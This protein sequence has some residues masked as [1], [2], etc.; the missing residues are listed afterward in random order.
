[1]LRQLAEAVRTRRVGARE[2]VTL[3][4]DRIERLDPGIGAVVALRPDDALAEAASMDE[5]VAS[6]EDPGPLAGIPCLIKDIEDLRGMRTTNGS[7]LLRDGPPADRDGVMAARLRA[8]GAIPVGKANTPEFA[9]EGFTANRVFGATR[10]PWAPEWSPGGSSGGSGAAI[11]AGMVPIGTATDTGGSIRIPG[12]FCGLVGLKPTRGAVATDPALCWPELTTCG[13]LAVS[14]ADLRMLLAVEAGEPLG[15]GGRPKR[16]VAVARLGHSG[17]LPGPVADAFT[18]ALEGLERDVGLSVETMEPEDLLRPGEPDAD[19]VAWTG[20]ELVTWLGRERAEAA[21]DLMFPTT[22][23]FVEAGL[24]TSEDEYRAARRRV[25][26]H[27]RSLDAV[28]DGDILIASP[29]LAVAGWLPE[30]PM[31]GSEEPGPPSNA[32]N[33]TVQNLT[34]HPAI[35][36]PAGRF[37]NGVPFGLQLTGPIGGD[38]MLLEVA[39]EWERARPWRVVAESYEPFEP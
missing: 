12:A 9:A 23:A 17:P 11:V 27:T 28:L 38:A 36:V 2:L 18:R 10:N 15:P 6:G 26:D 30:G 24:R 20:P 5:R 4:L 25:A 16:I 1:V 22:R 32:F 29:T 35:T 37:V 13:P 8:A 14:V 39:E 31:P 19:W 21:L 3:A 33:T 34:G 7:L